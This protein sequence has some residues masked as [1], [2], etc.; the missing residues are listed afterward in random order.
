LA[1]ADVPGMIERREILSGI[2][3]IGLQQVPQPRLTGN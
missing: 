2:T 3:L 1:L